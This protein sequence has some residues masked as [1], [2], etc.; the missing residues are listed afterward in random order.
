MKSAVLRPNLTTEARISSLN[1]TGIAAQ[2]TATGFARLGQL[3]DREE[4]ESLRSLYAE[5]SHFRSRIDMARYRFGKG[6]YQYFAYPLP[7]LV[8]ELRGALY[9][10]LA[11]AAAAWME[12]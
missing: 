10:G 1:W 6:E 12:A 4:C 3:L 7:Q 8:L 11:E 5:T 9:A 2:L